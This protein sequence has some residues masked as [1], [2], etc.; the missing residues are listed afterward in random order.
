MLPQLKIHVDGSGSVFRTAERGVLHIRVSMADKSQNESSDAVR[1]TSA[2]LTARF[3]THALKIEG[4][5]D[6]RPVPHPN[7]GITAFTA[8]S[9]S[10][11]AEPEFEWVDGRRRALDVMYRASSDF[12]VVFRD[13]QLLADVASELASMPHVSIVSTE[14]RLTAATRAEIER[15]ARKKAIENAVQKAQDYSG[16]VNRSVVA[17]EIKDGPASA[18][19]NIKNAWHPFSSTAGLFGSSGNMMQQQAPPQLQAQMQAQAQ[20]RA[21]QQTLNPSEQA[22]EGPSVE[23]RTITASA[24]V[25]VKFVSVDGEPVDM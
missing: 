24:T 18:A 15:E 7:A 22:K 5:V 25:N 16:V 6:G 13:M 11:R 21:Q 20:A 23:P 12:E 17:V 1:E 2:S 3:R 10:T 19:S 14:W 8:S 9:I 4:T